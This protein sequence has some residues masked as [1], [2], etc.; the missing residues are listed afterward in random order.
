MLYF[1]E[2]LCR[3]RAHLLLS[4][5]L[6]GG[7]YWSILPAMVNVWI[8]D[9]NYSHGFIIPFISAYAIYRNRDALKRA[10]VRPQNVGICIILFGL[11]LLI[12]ACLGTEYFTMRSSLLVLLAGMVLFLFG[13]EVFRAL[14][15]PLAYLMFMIPLPYIAYDTFAFPLKL[16]VATYSVLFLKMM[17]IIVW[18]E[19]NIIMFP[20]TVL[21]VADACSGIRSLMSLIA[22]A[23]AFAYFSQ[24]ST[25]KRVV[26]IASAVPIALFA[27]GLRVVVTGILAQHW[28]ARA[29]EGFFH[30]FAGMVVFWLA[31]VLLI[32]TGALVRSSK[33]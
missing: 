6:I 5:L 18:R 12:A 25:L 4:L 13:S 3:Y 8:D 7:L 20:S 33:W 14:L 31:V 26:V 11:L 30:E 27:N 21:E 22:L 1:G 17:G 32:I 16:L 24:Q 29:A 23:V 15:F 2:A 9:P 10:P 28:G 19:G